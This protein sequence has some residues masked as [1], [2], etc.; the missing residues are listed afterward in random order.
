MEEFDFNRLP[1][2]TPKQV[3]NER[4]LEN[5]QMV[6]WTAFAFAVFLAFIRL[7]VPSDSPSVI[8]TL[9]SDPLNPEAWAWAFGS[10]VPLSFLSAGA[11][12]CGLYGRRRSTKRALA[13]W[14]VALSIAVWLA[15][16]I[17]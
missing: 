5:W 13:A 4:Y 8:G 11:F 14:L 2:A 16:V 15:T 9:L 3:P 6:G 12:F 7:T 1:T 17:S 10:L